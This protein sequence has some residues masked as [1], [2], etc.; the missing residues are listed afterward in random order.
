M[1]TNRQGSLGAIL[2]VGYNTEPFI[3]GGGGGGGTPEKS[4]IF[5]K[6][7][8][9]LVLLLVPKFAKANRIEVLIMYKKKRDTFA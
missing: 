7:K 2:E 5:L 4:M 8:F 3:G 6:Q 9:H 1:N